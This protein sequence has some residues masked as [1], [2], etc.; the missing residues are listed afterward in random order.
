MQNLWH[1]H[2]SV[3]YIFFPL[4]VWKSYKSTENEGI[5]KNK[6]RIILHFLDILTRVSNTSCFNK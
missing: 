3:F 6:Y 4:F 2:G 5:D 1:E